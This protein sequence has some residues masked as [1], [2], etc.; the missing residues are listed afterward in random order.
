M[1]WGGITNH[2]YLY[3]GEVPGSA[4]CLAGYYHEGKQ[5]DKLDDSI[6]YISDFDS[7]LVV[8]CRKSYSS[9]DL[10]AIA[11]IDSTQSDSSGANTIVGTIP[12]AIAQSHRDVKGIG[13]L[14]RGAIRKTPD[15]YDI[16]VTSDREVRIHDGYKFGDNLIAGRMMKTF[17][18]LQTVNATHYSK[19]GGFRVWGSEQATA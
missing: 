10:G 3:Y 12:I 5:W 13:L 6:V 19:R 18:K 9:Y 14:N 17:E 1:I 2:C 11:T 8:Y 7:A 16:L 15:G 4:Q